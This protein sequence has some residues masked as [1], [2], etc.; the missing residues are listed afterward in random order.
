[1]LMREEGR[2]AERFAC[3]A[4]ASE[5]RE[6][7]HKLQAYLGSLPALASAVRRLLGSG[8]PALGTSADKAAG[9]SAQNGIDRGSEDVAA[10]RRSL[11]AKLAMQALLGMLRP[12][13]ASSAC[14]GESGPERP[15][16]AFLPGWQH[17]AALNFA[18]TLLS[19]PALLSGMPSQVRTQLTSLKAFKI[20]VPAVEMVASQQP[21]SKPVQG[22]DCLPPSTPCRA[23]CQRYI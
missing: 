19:A 16:Q 12:P 18:K 14:G 6:A 15:D 13:Q 11:T 22:I 1:M 8:Q 23:S 3:Y 10:A 5:A 7:A 2:R 17:I 20:V 4:G 9:A 21:S